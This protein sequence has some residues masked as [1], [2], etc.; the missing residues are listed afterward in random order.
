MRGC[1]F[2]A[3]ASVSTGVGEGKGAGSNVDVGVG[4]CVGIVM[5]NILVVYDGRESVYGAF[6]MAIS[7]VHMQMLSSPHD[8]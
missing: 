2:G 1:R 8:G 7:F 3:C 6:S 4:V 5:G